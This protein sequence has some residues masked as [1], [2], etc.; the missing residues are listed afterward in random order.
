MYQVLARKWR[1]QTF[2]Q[3]VGQPH[4]QQSL[5]NAVD[6]DRLAH[7][8]IFAGLRGTGKTTVARILAKCLNCEK[9]PTTT[10]CSSC[11]PCTVSARASSPGRK[12]ST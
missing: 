1:P 7:A 10:P 4:V 6:S 11:S 5:V 2:E 12:C 3:L 8:Y 9:G